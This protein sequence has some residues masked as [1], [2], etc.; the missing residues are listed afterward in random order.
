MTFFCGHTSV[1]QLVA[2]TFYLFFSLSLLSISSSL[3]LFYLFLSLS[4]FPSSLTLSFLSISPT[5]SLSLSLSLLPPT[6]LFLSHIHKISTINK[7]TPINFFMNF[8]FTKYAWILTFLVEHYTIKM[9]IIRCYLLLNSTILK[10]YSAEEVRIP[11]FQ[12][13][14]PR[15]DTNLHK[16]VRL[17]F[18]RSVSIPSL[19][20][21]Q[22]Y[23]DPK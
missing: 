13:E 4:H 23:P 19:H 18:W 11:F 22:L 9:D 17:W 16:M 2:K 8:F 14:C 15:Y 7:Y 12:S 1:G 3:F 5:L 21:S 10:L 6:Y 20:Y